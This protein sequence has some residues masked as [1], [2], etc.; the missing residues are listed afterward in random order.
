M[1]FGGVLGGLFNAL[2]APLV[3]PTVA[4]YPIAMALACLLLPAAARESS[5]RARRLDLGLPLALGGATVLVLW[6]LESLAPTADLLPRVV[7]FSLLAG[8]CYLF[9]SRPLRYCLGVAALLLVSMCSGVIAGRLEHIERS[10]FSV[11]RVMVDADG[12]YRL[13]FHGTTSHGLQSL[14]PARRREPLAYYYRTGPIGQVFSEFRGPAAKPH[15]AIV[16]LGIGSMACYAEPGQHLTF[17]EIDPAVAR[18]ASDPRYFTFLQECR[19]K[20]DL[21]LGDGRLTLARAPDKHYG[22]IVVDAFSSDVIPMHLVTREALAVYL[23][24]LT[25]DG[26]LAFH[27]SNRYFDLEPLLGDL[28]HSAG[29]V[30]RAQ[31]EADEDISEKERSLGKLAS[32]SVIMARKAAHLGKLA[33]DRRWKDVIGRPEEQVCSDDFSPNIFKLFRKGTPARERPDRSTARAK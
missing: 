30:C 4:E 33:T 3:F 11:H 2:L 12:K 20:Y 22:M 6:G 26:I 25:D 15:I 5:T 8:C 16:G 13:L 23:A 29:L 9:A 17:Y 21:V 19:G 18:I 28:A 10:F 31:L 27:V 24:K 1:S 32:H 14:E 7:V